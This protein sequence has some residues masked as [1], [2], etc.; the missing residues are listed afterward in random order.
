MKNT[1]QLLCQ[2]TTVNAVTCLLLRTRSLACCMQDAYPQINPVCLIVYRMSRLCGGT[3]EISGIPAPLCL[4]GWVV[5]GFMGWVGEWWCG[6]WWDEWCVHDEWV[7]FVVVVVWMV[8]VFGGV[9]SGWWCW[10]CAGEV[11]VV[12]WVGDGVGGVLVRGGVGWCCVGWLVVWVM[13]FMPKCNF[14]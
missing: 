2:C 5:G 11:G 7:C 14:F 10:W 3:H 6:W 4:H 9:F 1:D 13:F 12:Y 8:G